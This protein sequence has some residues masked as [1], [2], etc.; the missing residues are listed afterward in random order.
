[1]LSH[2]NKRIGFQI[3]LRLKSML[4]HVNNIREFM[5]IL[6][7][8]KHAIACISSKI[9]ILAKRVKKG[10]HATACC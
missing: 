3:L 5:A 2:D 10:K 6:R 8:K 7:L 9:K 1:M 4:P